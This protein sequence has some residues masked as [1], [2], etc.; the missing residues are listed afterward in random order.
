MQA[1][2]QFGI[3]IP[4]GFSKEPVD[5]ALIEKFLEQADALGYHSLWVQ[6]VIDAALLE[7]VTLLTYAAAFTQRIRLGSA[8]LL[9]A[10]RSPVQLA[11]TLS[12]LDQLSRGRLIVG[13]GL[14]SNTEV[15]PSYGISTEKRLRRFIDGI[16]LLKALWTEE[17]VSR[18]GEFWKIVNGRLELKPVQKPHPP[19]WFG[20]SHPNAL[21]RA[22]KLGNGWLGGRT[23]T[24]KFRTHVAHVLQSLD[25]FKRDPA[26]FMIGKR[27]YIAVDGDK[28]RAERRLNEWFNQVYGVVGNI[29]RSAAIYG[30][31]QECVDKLGELVTAGAKL[32]ILNPVSH[33]LEHLQSL[34]SKVLPKINSAWSKSA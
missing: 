1:A 3:A 25:E 23:S 24:E 14:G 31:D 17:Q 5:V 34:A 27:V 28:D 4:Q 2:V 13:V 26:D 9:T 21:R 10:L 19:L 8:I 22:A 15:Y 18:E 6:E 30:G 16:D 32:L 33:H 11:K 12:S 7:P 29:A 20:G